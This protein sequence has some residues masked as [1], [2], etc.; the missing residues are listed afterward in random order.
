MAEENSLLDKLDGLKSRFEEISTL[1]TDP[2]VIADQGRYVKLSKEYKDLENLMQAR[3]EYSR[4]LS[5]LNESK[6]ICSTKTMRS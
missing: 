6:Q 2:N 5:N 3:D 1:I 4:L